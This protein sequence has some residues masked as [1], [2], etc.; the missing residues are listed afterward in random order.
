MF[1]MSISYKYNT[2]PFVPKRALRFAN[3]KGSTFLRLSKGE[4]I[5]SL[6]SLERSLRYLS[7]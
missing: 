1:L 7:H 4:S 6:L 3:V 5:V 2:K